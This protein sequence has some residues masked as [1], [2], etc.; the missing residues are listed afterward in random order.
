[1]LTLRHKLISSAILLFALLAT[2][3][4]VGSNLPP[5]TWYIPDGSTL[6]ATQMTDFFDTNQLYFNVQSATNSNGE[7]RGEISPSSGIYQTDAGDPFAANPSNTPVTFATL[8]E[9]SQARPRNV[10]T[11]ASGYGSVTLDPQSKILSGFI[12]TSGISGSNAR[13]HDALPGSSG[14]TVL[15]LE[16]GPVVWTI[17]VNTVLNDSQ[18]ARLTA[19]AYYFNVSSAAFPDGE[20]RGQL[21]QQVRF[22][23]L[24]GDNEVPAISTSG[25]GTG[26]LALNPATRQVSGFIKADGLGSLVTAAVIRFGDPATNG[27]GIIDLVNRGNGIWSVPILD[28]P[29]LSN[30]VID[31]FNSDTLY[32]NVH[33]QAN[34]GGEVR[35]QILKAGIRIGT[36]SLDGFKEIPPVSTLATGTGILAWNSVTGQVSGSIKTD[37]IVG[38][39]AHI[40]SGPVS[41]NGPPLIA[42]TTTSPVAVAPTPGISFGLDI[43]PIYNASCGTT[44][45][46]C[47]VTGGNAPMSLQTGL[48]YPNSLVRLV[49]GDSVSSYLYQRLT[50][51]DP[52]TFP[53]MPLNRTPLSTIKL[54]LFKSWI[55]SGALF[56]YYTP[57]VTLAVNPAAPQ[58]PGTPVTFTATAQG[59]GGVYEYRF[60]LNSGSGYTIVQDYSAANT[61][62][63]TPALAGN[64]DI[65]ADVR[66]VGSTAVR[67][68]FAKIFF[69]QIVSAATIG[70]T[71]T[72]DLV[73]PQTV[74]T[75]ITITATGQGGSGSYEYRFWINSGSGYNIVQNYSATNTFVWTPL[76]TGAH[77]I[78][79]DVRAAGSTVLR[80]AFVKLFY[81]QIVPSAATGVTV[82][83]DLASPQATGTP[84]TFTAH[85]QGGS[86]SYEYRFWLN[87]GS[88]YSIVQDYSTATAFV[89]TPGATGAYDILV[90]VRNAG[91]TSFREALTKLF[92]YQIQ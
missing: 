19:G 71:A 74:N 21:N 29:V 48:S 89:W 84:V 22:V 88:G 72:P 39:F 16:G 38:T 45:T 6:T 17:P 80:D 14:A 90:D 46:F 27:P 50:I 20:I 65:L 91:S 59:G 8:L 34:P 81:Y 43:Q 82:T 55:D 23:S 70:V 49:P 69:Y 66:N 1:M 40:H 12:V 67:D 86:G 10:I 75:P 31:A 5:A 62:V 60:W 24:R 11:G 73:S 52:P 78:L 9:G 85:G 41:A 25:R 92:F 35:G 36:A 30:A 64:Y 13:I 18:I 15:T 87:S 61:F 42:L 54:D 33:T 7:I 44:S 28:N 26:F 56:D 53:Q 57:S 76:T 51:N 47:H 77:D 37:S 68:S 3:S 32:V 58:S 63:W 79:V 2:A 83:P 4:F